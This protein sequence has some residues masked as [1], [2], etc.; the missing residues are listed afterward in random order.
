MT[1]PPPDTFRPADE[2]TLVQHC[3]ACPKPAWHVI[4][5]EYRA[6]AL[7]RTSITALGFGTFL[8]LI[9]YRVAATKERPA[10]TET[11]FAF[12]GYIFAQWLPHQRWQAIRSARG[13]AGILTDVGST[14]V[15]ATVPASFM[16]AMIARANAAGILEDLSAPDI[17]PALPAMTWVR[18]SAGPLAGRLA[19][20]EWSTE[21]RVG[22][23]L[24][25]LGGE[26]RAKLRRDAVVPTERPL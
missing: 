20:C 13:V 12:P 4:S 18:I 9:R 5:T 7:A 15:P 26:R 17:L 3:G 10:R 6:E 21:D 14:E 19:L 11:S 1:T 24:E 8:P 22:L 25:V 16:G 2:P 23:L